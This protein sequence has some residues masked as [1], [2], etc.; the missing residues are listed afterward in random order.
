MRKPELV[1][2]AHGTSEL[3]RARQEAGQKPRTIFSAASFQH[4]VFPPVRWMVEGIL[5]EG[6]TIFAGKPKMG[7]SYMMLNV[8]A[9]IATGGVA[10][11][12]VQCTPG[13]VLMVALEDPRRRIHQRLKQLLGDRPW[14]ERL[15]ILLDMPRLHEGGLAL[16]RDFLDHAANP[17]LVCID[18]LALVRPPASNRNTPYTDDYDAI[19]PLQKLAGER[20]VAIVLVHHLRKG[21]ADDPFDEVSGTTGLTGAADSTLT[22]KREPGRADAILYGRGRDLEEF[23]QAFAFDKERGLWTLLGAADDYRH[24]ED[25]TAILEVLKGA[26]EATTVSDIHNA[27]GETTLTTDAIK[28]A[29]Y[30]MEKAGLVKKQGR[31]KF[32]VI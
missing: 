24:S 27:L 7:K 10:F 5:P 20:G 25:R 8:A 19:S 26:A 16:V 23:E 9:A 31:G 13:D 30:R 22:L 28:Q 29:L 15:Q 1:V 6:A 14:P 12:K 21:A 11:S 3:Y 4:E 17:A 18:T 32:V 2:A